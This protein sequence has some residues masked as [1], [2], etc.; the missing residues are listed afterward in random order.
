MFR[1]VVLTC[2][3]AAS[4][5]QL[6]EEKNAKIVKEQRFNAGDGRAG[7]AFATENEIVYRE[8]TALDGSR[9]GQYSYIGDD[10][11]TYTVK[12]SAGK[13]GFRILE[14]AH[15]PSGGQD[16][17]AFVA[18]PA[19]EPAQQ[20][21]IAQPQPAPRARPAPRPAPVQQQRL[22]APEPQFI[23]D[24]DLADEAGTDPNFNP[25]IN[26]HDPTHRNF[27]FNKNG[28]KFAPKV[29]GVLDGSFVPNCAGCE[30]LNPF[31]NPF[32]QSHNNAGF[33]AGQRA[34]AAQQPAR[35][36][37]PIQN[38]RPTGRVIAQPQQPARP[39]IQ[40]TPSPKRFF[41]PGQIKLNRFET[42]F[43][44]DFES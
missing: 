15:I 24:Y 3:I 39:L 35:R 18:T 12:Y 8:E 2:A 34:A 43:N 28:A 42:G 26:P 25:F 33:L 27:A 1:L 30:G 20:Q 10:G 23:P 7:S 13:E 29:P 31:V 41:P 22:P 9:I 6:V 40:T 32:D 14:G 38:A 11:Q 21:P 37:A 4:C 16:A 44:F 17:A 36:P 5:G 19:P